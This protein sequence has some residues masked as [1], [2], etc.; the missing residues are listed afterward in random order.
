MFYNDVDIVK[1]RMNAAGVARRPFLF[2]VNFSM[3]EAFF[4]DNP[5]QQTDILFSIHE[6]HNKTKREVDTD[7]IIFESRPVSYADYQSRFD[8]VSRGLHRGDSFLTNLTIATP[9]NTNLSLSDIFELSK[10]PYQLYI[11]DRFVCFSPE[12]FIK[13]EKGVISTN[14]MKGTIDA[15]CVDA[16]SVL[17]NDFKETAEHSTIVDLLRNDLSMVADRVSV[18]RFRY[19]DKIEARNKT[20]LQVSSEIRGILP[21]DYCRHLGDIVF[22]MLPAGSISGAPKQATIDLIRK[23]ELSDRGFYTGIFGFFD[24]EVLDTAVLIRFI[25]IDSHHQMF[26]RSGGGITAYSDCRSEYDE[27]QSKIYLPFR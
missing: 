8:I 26:F 3:T 15:T 4:V 9:I 13:I 5:L 19:I 24:G 16:E 7:N 27:V 11:P 23:A 18:D 22:K 21:L 10:S 6:Q 1:Q 25:E 2:G 20:I 14:P 12:R 17:L